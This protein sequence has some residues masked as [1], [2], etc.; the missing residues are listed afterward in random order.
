MSDILERPQPKDDRLVVDGSYVREQA[1]E[2]ATLFLTPVSGVYRALF[3]S[4][5]MR[6]RRARNRAA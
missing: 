2:A 3:G 4:A 6:K 5:R 1:R